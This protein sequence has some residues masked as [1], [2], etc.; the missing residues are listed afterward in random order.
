MKK[1]KL[2]GKAFRLFSYAT[3]ALAIYGMAIDALDDKDKEP[4][5]S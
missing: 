1:I 5:K 4:A 3:G 2:I